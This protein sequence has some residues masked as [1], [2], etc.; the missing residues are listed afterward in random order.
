MKDALYKEGTF[1]FNKLLLIPV[2]ELHE[3]KRS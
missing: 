2:C 3:F 1:N